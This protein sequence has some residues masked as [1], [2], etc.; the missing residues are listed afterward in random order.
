MARRAKRGAMVAVPEV[1]YNGLLS[2]IGELLEE[3]RR[4]T[5]RVVNSLL[6]GTYWEVGRR[7]VEFE[8]GGKERAEYGQ[9]LWKK[10][11]ADLTAK[12]GRGFSKSNLAQMRGLYLGWQIFQTPSGKLEARVISQTPSGIS[13]AGIAQAPSAQSAVVTSA[14]RLPDL[15]D[16]MALAPAFPLPWSQYVGLMAVTNLHAR[17]FYEG[18]AIR[19]GWSVRQLDRQIGTQFYERVAHSQR[20]TVLLAKGQEPRPEDAVAVQDMIRDPYLV[21]FLD[22]K[23]EYSE[24]DMEEAL[25]RPLEWFLLEL[26]AGFAFVAR[27]KRVRVGHSWYRMDLL[28]Y[29]RGLRCLV[30][31]DLKTGPFAP[32]D[33]GQMNLY[34]NYAREHLTMPGEADPVGLIL[35]SDKSDAVVKYATAGINTHVFASQYLKK[36]PDEETLRQEIL[37][38]R[39]ALATR[40]AARGD[41]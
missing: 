19:G 31:I 4:S 38:T 5:A 13:T 37:K 16:L 6:T 36:L 25:I 23:D 11:A 18:E 33:A 1:D 24:S 8:Q 34:L 15:P 28:L 2:G 29:H 7:I 20:P 39:R 35:C 17:A 26:G 12:F 21:E 14:S 9:G 22:L 3:A 32:A 41:T 27:Q 30:I 40:A 10:L